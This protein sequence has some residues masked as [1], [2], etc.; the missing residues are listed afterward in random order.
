ME[1]LWSKIVELPWLE[2]V[3]GFVLGLL[4][5]PIGNRIGAFSWGIVSR[6]MS[7]ASSSHR[8]REER[9]RAWR[10]Q[11]VAFLAEHSDI[12]GEMTTE[13][14]WNLFLAACLTVI[15]IRAGHLTGHPE[16]AVG[17]ASISG[18]FAYWAGVTR[19]IVL[20]ARQLAI[21]KR[22][23]GAPL[24]SSETTESPAPRANT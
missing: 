4:F 1:N 3:A 13:A 10:D 8:R 20:D 11:E 17:F 7:W 19:A 2:L 12:R 24:P 9:F 18:Y 5:T 6:G 21:S 22:T 14:L 23:G 15:G 16:F